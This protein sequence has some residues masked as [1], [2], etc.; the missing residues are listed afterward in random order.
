MPEPEFL[1][2][3]GPQASI[4]Q[5]RFL[6]RINTVVELILWRRTKSVPALKMNI[7]WD[8]AGSIPYLLPTQFQEIIFPPITR[9]YKLP[10]T[11]FLSRSQGGCVHSEAEFLDD[12]QT[13][14]FRVFLLAIHSHLYSF[15][16]RFSFLQTYTTSYSSVTVHC[17]GE[18]RKA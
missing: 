12:I 14:V 6:A 17:K 18:R 13:K 15:A 1:N 11:I 2:F 16:L 5:N 7:L 3:S 4:L 8:M 9:L 10:A